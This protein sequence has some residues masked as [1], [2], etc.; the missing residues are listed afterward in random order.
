[1]SEPSLSDRLTLAGGPTVTDVGIRV[2]GPTLSVGGLTIAW[3]ELVDYHDRGTNITVPPT[4]PT[5]RVVQ[6]D[7]ARATSAATFGVAVFKQTTLLDR[8]D[9]RGVLVDHAF[10]VA[11]H[12]DLRGGQPGGGHRRHDRRDVLD[13]GAPRQAPRRPRCERPGCAAVRRTRPRLVG[14][15]RV[16]SSELHGGPR[17]RRGDRRLAVALS[18]R[19][20]RLYSTRA[21]TR[22]FGMPQSSRTSRVCWPGCAGGRVISTVVRLNRGAGAGCVSAV[23]LD[24]RRPG[25]VVRVVGGLAHREHRGEAHVGVLHQRAPLVAGLGGEHVGDPGLQR[26]PATLVHLPGELLVAIEA[27]DAHQLGV[28]LRLDRAD[29]D[30][31]AVGAAVDVVEVRAGVEQVGAALLAPDPGLRH[32]PEHRHQR[33]RAVDHR[34]VD[35]L[36]LAAALRLEQGADHAVGEEHAAAAEV[37]DEVQ[38]RHRCL[39]GAADVG[40]GAGERDV[41]DVVAGPRRVRA[42]PGPTR[43]CGRTP[44]SGC[45]RGTRPVRRP[46]APSPPAGTP[47]S[48][49]RRARRGRAASPRRQG[50]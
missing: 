1:M 17:H 3:L 22:S 26:R 9:A 32:R 12:Q 10:R 34:G 28:E 13:R 48:A 35:D 30:V 24:E 5:L 21:S 50:S 7:H 20:P 33:R 16:G 29:R 15:D 49:R 38:R 25:D 40:E 27:G 37:A 8:A 44:A 39:T 42:R 45:G 47:R 31:L 6:L 46:A 18:S 11:R 4:W 19:R 2:D 36:P 41:V 23:D 43:S 14:R